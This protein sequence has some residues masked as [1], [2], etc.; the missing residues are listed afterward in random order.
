MTQRARR[1]GR[2]GRLAIV[3]MLGLAGCAGE[4]LFQLQVATG[5]SGPG[6]T[7]TTPDEGSTAQV[8]EQLG[9]GFD[10]GDPATAASYTIDGRY[11][12]DQSAA[13]QT[14]TN[15]LEENLNVASDFTFIFPVA[16]QTAGDVYIVVALTNDAGEV[17]KD[18]VKITLTN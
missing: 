4:N 12:D 9:V 7:I 18:S 17:G 11:A 1:Q 2:L 3:S 8:G 10:I 15:Q 14:V 16:G 13:Y 5:E 6:V